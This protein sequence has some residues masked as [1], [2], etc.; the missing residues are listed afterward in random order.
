[1]ATV[2]AFV[3]PKS[4]RNGVSKNNFHEEEMAELLG[5]TV[6]EVFEKMPI[7]DSPFKLADRINKK[8]ALG[9]DVS[10]EE[11]I[12]KARRLDKDYFQSL[13]DEIKSEPHLMP[14]QIDKLVGLA[15]D[16]L[17]ELRNVYATA[18]ARD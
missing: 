11:S 5:I 8:K 10:V 16:L 15:R 18:S 1:V 6:E 4:R 2:W 17:Q 9:L 14:E 7:P 12:R 13:R 3:I